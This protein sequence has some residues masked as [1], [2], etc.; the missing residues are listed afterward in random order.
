MARKTKQQEIDELQAKLQE[1]YELLEKE[2]QLTNKLLEQA[3]ND[4][5]NSSYRKQLEAENARLRE[6]AGS[7]DRL[8]NKYDDLKIKYVELSEMPKAGRK[9]HNEAWT[10]QYQKFCDMIENGKSMNEIMQELEISRAT[11]FRLKK[12]WKVAAVT[13]E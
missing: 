10:N 4:F 7:Y 11:F 5:A 6:V 3:D 9:P 1:V 8:K 2:Q 12:Q 13:K